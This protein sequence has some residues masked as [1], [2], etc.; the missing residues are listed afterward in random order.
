VRLIGEF[1]SLLALAYLAEHNGSERPYQILLGIFF[2]FFLPTLVLNDGALRSARRLIV[3]AKESHT[4]G[5]HI[6]VGALGVFV[7]YAT[8]EGL[9]KLMDD[10]RLHGM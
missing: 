1:V 8:Y 4:V 6:L 3:G 7:C 5:A 2:A 10:W 9:A